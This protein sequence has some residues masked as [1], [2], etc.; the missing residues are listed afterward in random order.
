[1]GNSRQE[2]PKSEMTYSFSRA[3]ARPFPAITDLK[4]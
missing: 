3:A 4:H 2:S 1:M